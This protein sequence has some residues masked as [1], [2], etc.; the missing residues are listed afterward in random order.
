MLW[1]G[2]PER[3]A[4]VLGTIAAL[5]AHTLTIAPTFLIP[6]WT[7][8]GLGLAA[9]GWLAGAPALGMVLGL[10]PWGWLIDKRGERS[11]IVAGLIVAAAAD[12]GASYLAGYRQLW[13]L[14]LVG[15]VAAASVNTASSR[16]VAGYFPAARRGRV[17]GIRQAAQP[18]GTA[19]A[20]ILVP[21]IADSCGP[22]CALLG[23]AFLCG[24]VGVASLLLVRDPGRLL[25]GTQ[26]PQVRSPYRDASRFLLRIHLVGML[27]AVPQALVWTF[28]FAWL[29]SEQS[30]ATVDASLLVVAT[31]LL[32]AVG[33]VAAGHWSD[34]AGSR[35]TPIRH[36]AT[37]VA[38]VLVLLGI[39]AAAG[40]RLAVP[41][42]VALGVLS[43]ADNGLTVTAVVEYA[44]MRYSGRALGVQSMGQLLVG[45]FSGPVFGAVIAAAGY[46]A[47]FAMAAIAP[48]AATFAVPGW[49]ANRP[50]RFDLDRD[51]G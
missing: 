39:A 14:L 2:A 33:R 9:A 47:M 27:L 44:G 48:F 6:T 7:T 28:M 31:Q 20:A 1:P 50:R 36:I 26:A 10:V 3:R 34:A 45:A 40:L 46:P 22:G 15:G 11:S 51:G 41:C 21:G 25:P 32:S 35:T 17:M 29:C 37:S 30:W 18:L 43:V 42:I 13:A 5:S 4:V 8:H 38:M 24:G 49:P 12:A 19:L 23:P 16:L